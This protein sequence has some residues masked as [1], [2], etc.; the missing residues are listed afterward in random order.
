[1]DNKRSLVKHDA[2]S[3]NITMRF[4]KVVWYLRKYD[5]FSETHMVNCQNCKKETKLKYIS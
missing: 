2:H 3:V 1:M 5:L 4:C